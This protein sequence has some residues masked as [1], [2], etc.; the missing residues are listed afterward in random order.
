MNNVRRD[1]V[2]HNFSSTESI[3]LEK[4]LNTFTIGDIV[5]SRFLQILTFQNDI[6]QYLRHYQD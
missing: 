1:T 4:C 3:R 5:F 2:K 6:Y